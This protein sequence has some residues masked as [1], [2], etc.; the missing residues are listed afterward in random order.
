[1][2]FDIGI[3]A[4]T[5]RAEA[6]ADLAERTNAI[7]LSQDDGLLG[8][9]I[10]HLK[11]WGWLAEHSDAD[12]CVV[13]EDDAIVPVDIVSQMGKVLDAAP[14]DL[15][16]LYRGHN[17]NN[18]AFELNGLAAGVAADDSGAHWV[19]GDHLLHAVGVALRLSV[20][21][22][23]LAH[24]R[25]LPANFPIDQG[26]SHW[27]RGTAESKTQ[28]C[29]CWPSIVDHADG[30]SAIGRHPDKLPRP[31][32]RI[33]YRYGSRIAWNSEAVLL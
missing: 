19:M 32:G 1:M 8:C 27:S 20:I 33:A 29:Y 10:N 15:V 31:K 28:T 3:V 24:V 22:D 4:H 17:V 11:V 30:A 16:S 18:P 26:I 13:L 21:C 14:G 5:S 12:W 23:M 25:L 7:Y 9:N 2:T 6:A